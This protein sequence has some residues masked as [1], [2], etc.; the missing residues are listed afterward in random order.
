MGNFLLLGICLFIGIALQKIKA[1]PNDAYKT[2]NGFI[3]YVSLPALA[4][5]YIPF[6]EFNKD[7]FIAISMLWVF[8]VVIFFL[9]EGI[10]KVMKW[11]RS[12]L[13]CL[14][15]TCGLS[16]TAFVGFPL[17]E[18]FYGEEGLVVGMIVHYLGSL[19]VLSTVG[20]A[21]ATFAGGEKVKWKNLGLDLLKFPPFS[22]FLLAM[23]LGQVGRPDWFPLVYVDVS[24]E[25]LGKL[26]AT[27]TPLALIS[28]GLQLRLQLD[29]KLFQTMSIGLSLKLLIGPLLMWLAYV[30]IIGIDTP[31]IEIAIFDCAMPPMV[32]GAIIAGLYGHRPQ[33]ASLMVGVGTI[34]GMGTVYGWYLFLS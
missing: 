31:M 15:L 1:F 20:V 12:T 29:M 11:D 9:L 16:N 33:L 17:I 26:G 23:I 4:L 7:A 18:T 25:V 19:L 10:G 14:L 27:M 5:L 13:M 22:F 30:Q 28:V 8:F 21:A 2:L 32:T 24:K 6:I 3:I 34:I